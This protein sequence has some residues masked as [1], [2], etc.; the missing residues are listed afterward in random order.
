MA[1]FTS[2][3]TKIFVSTATPATFDA[4]GFAA[5]TWIEV[6][7]IQSISPYGYSRQPVEYNELSEEGMQTAKGQAIFGGVAGD[8]T[9][10]STDAGQNIVRADIENPTSS[11][12]VKVLLPDGSLT[13]GY[14]PSLSGQ[15]NPGSANNMVTSAFDI[16][17]N[18]RP[19]EVAA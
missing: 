17:F 14:G 5:L 13:Y 1:V 16:R 11:L 15:K 19:V 12:S 10:N 8:M 9:Y 18:K 4:V 2:S 7:H 3:G 6:K